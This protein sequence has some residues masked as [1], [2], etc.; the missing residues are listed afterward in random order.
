MAR[1]SFDQGPRLPRLG[2][3]GI[4]SRCS[5][6]EARC[7][8]WQGTRLRRRCR[9]AENERRKQEEAAEESRRIQRDRLG[10]SERGATVLSVFFF[11]FLSSFS[12]SLSVAFL[13]ESLL[14][15][16]PDPA[17]DKDSR[18]GCCESGEEKGRRRGR[19]GKKE[20]ESGRRISEE[21]FNCFHCWK[22]KK[23]KKTERA[24][25]NVSPTRAALWLASSLASLPPRRRVFLCRPTPHEAKQQRQKNKMASNAAIEGVAGAAAGMVA[26]V[27]TYPLMTVSFFFFLPCA[28]DAGGC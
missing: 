24:S 28:S 10:A 23:K 2:A 21:R 7:T 4:A 25:K 3:F 22:K 11:I 1:V 18:H 19:D 17:G 6:L 26:L 14:T 13:P 12:L 8:L 9:E 16:V 27:A 5:M 20:Q 15:D